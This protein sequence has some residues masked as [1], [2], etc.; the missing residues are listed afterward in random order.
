MV[1]SEFDLGFWFVSYRIFLTSSSSGARKDSF[2]LTRCLR[3][4]RRWPGRTVHYTR[5]RPLF[6]AYRTPERL[7]AVRHSV[8]AAAFFYAKCSSSTA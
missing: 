4:R 5:A 3:A 6:L 8:C 2:S 1:Q 7:H